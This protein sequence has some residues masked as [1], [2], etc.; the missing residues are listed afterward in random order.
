ME[1]QEVRWLGWG[2]GGGADPSTGW[3]QCIQ[4][5]P[6]VA[7]PECSQQGADCCGC[8]WGAEEGRLSAGGQHR[9]GPQCPGKAVKWEGHMQGGRSTCGEREG[10]GEE[11]AGGK[12]GDDWLWL[13]GDMQVQ[14]VGVG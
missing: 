9:A 14:T 8:T 13:E 3:Q 10:E 12:P 7:R 1:L 4:P 5:Y 6:Q 2:R 11:G